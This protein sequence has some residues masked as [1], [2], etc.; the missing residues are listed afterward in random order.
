MQKIYEADV[1]MCIQRVA[2]HSM[3][4][5]EREHHSEFESLSILDLVEV[6]IKLLRRA[7]GPKIAVKMI[8]RLEARGYEIIPGE[9]PMRLTTKRMRQRF[10]NAI[11]D[12]VAAASEKLEGV[13]WQ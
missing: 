2:L 3:A 12:A 5:Y 1:L 6:R 8:K 11:H 13:T 4:R 10:C 9:G 7:F